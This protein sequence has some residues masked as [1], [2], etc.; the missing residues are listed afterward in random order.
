MALDEWLFKLVEGSS[1]LFFLTEWGSLATRELSGMT[2]LCRHPDMEQNVIEQCELLREDVKEGNFEYE[3]LFTMVFLWEDSSVTPYFF[4]ATEETGRDGFKLS[5]NLSDTKSTNTSRRFFARW[6]DDY[7]RHIGQLS[8]A[9]F[10]ENGI[11]ASKVKAKWITDLFD[12]AGEYYHPKVGIWF[13]AKAWSRSDVNWEGEHLY[14][15][16]LVAALKRL[17][18]AK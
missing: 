7:E 14:L 15:T 9:M 11:K 17:T 18:K 10:P 16:D 3:G 6:G 8:N 4:T 1:P 2:L 13:I 12:K 5:K